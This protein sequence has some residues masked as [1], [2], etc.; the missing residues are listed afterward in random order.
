MSQ[1]IKSY[2]P[3]LSGKTTRAR[4]EIEKGVNDGQ[5]CTDVEEP[6]PARE[7]GGCERI[8]SGRNNTFIVL[9]RD[10]PASIASGMGGA[11]GTQCGMID[12][13]VGLGALT[14]IKVLK[15]PAGRMGSFVGAPENKG[16]HG[17]ESQVSPNFFA[18]AARIY[19]TQRCTPNG[20]IDSYLGMKKMKGAS[21]EG[22]SAIAVKADHVRIVGRENVR[23]YA[24]RAQKVQGFGMEGETTTLGT[25]IGKTTIELVAGREEDL[26]P[27][28]L[29]NNLLSYLQLQSDMLYDVF[30]VILDVLSNLIELNT[31]NP[32]T[33]RYITK[34]LNS[35]FTMVIESLNKKISAINSLDEL[36]IQ[37]ANSIVS[38]TVFIT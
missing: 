36:P 31:A 8:I 24:A 18:D 11:G 7:A 22:K 6:V 32:L 21:S 37:G 16:L 5:F 19:M 25:R 1:K 14:A 12:M 35:F 17:R 20:G 2:I 28:V 27:A 13:T 3:D 23:I 26:Q 33:A 30:K 9:G 29:G 15:T 10:R 38:D 4:R 34:N